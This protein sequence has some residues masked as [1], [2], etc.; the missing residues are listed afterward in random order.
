MKND[1][2]EKYQFL[3]IKVS[4]KLLILITSFNVYSGLFFDS[5]PPQTPPPRITRN[6]EC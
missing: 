3:H 1:L 2:K 6:A 4:S 5:D